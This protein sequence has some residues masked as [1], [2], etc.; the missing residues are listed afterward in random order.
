MRYFRMF[1]AGCVVAGLACLVIG[2]RAS[3][4]LPG[5]CNARHALTDYDKAEAIVIGKVVV[6]ERVLEKLQLANGREDYR[7][8]YYAAVRVGRA[9]KGELRVGDEF[10]TLVG[11]YDQTREDD[12]VSIGLR[13]CGTHP[14]F[15]L[16][17]G[18]VNL[19]FINKIKDLRHWHV[20]NKTYQVLRDERARKL[21]VEDNVWKP[22][23]CHYSIHEIIG[24]RGERG[25]MTLWVNEARGDAEQEIL[26]NDFLSRKR[27]EARTVKEKAR[28]TDVPK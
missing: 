9:I 11:E 19:Y 7:F 20:D 4:Y 13:T 2:G 16:S 14:A 17:P 24:V 15:R 23:S 1:V 25:G 21:I 22:R 26:L 6:I 12:T 8:S 3:A 18:G 10:R 5:N 27:E 28:R